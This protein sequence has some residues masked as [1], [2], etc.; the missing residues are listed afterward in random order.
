MKLKR[1]IMNFDFT[2]PK[3]GG[4]GG[5][6]TIYYLLEGPRTLFFFLQ[7]LVRTLCTS[8]IIRDIKQLS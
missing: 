5:C 4:G 2:V 6:Y 3:G 8:G 7:N 1:I